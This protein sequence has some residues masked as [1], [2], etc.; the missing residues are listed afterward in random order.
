MPG[1]LSE[2]APAAPAA[3]AESDVRT[4]LARLAASNA[5]RT[6]VLQL[7]AMAV[8]AGM[9]WAEDAR[10]AALL[11]FGMALLVGLWRV[12]LGRVACAPDDPSAFEPQRVT[13]SLTANAVM[14]GLTWMLASVTILPRLGPMEEAVY[15]LL[16]CGT[17]VVGA[18]FLPFA[19]S[20]YTILVALQVLGL[21]VALVDAGNAWSLAVLA[22]CAPFGRSL[23]LAARTY[24]DT[25][26]C[27]I[28]SG[29]QARLALAA[30]EHSRDAE[31]RASEAKS[32][33]LATLS[34]EIRTPMSGVLGA[35]DLLRHAGLTPAQVALAE[36]AASSGESLLRIVNDV[37]DHAQLESGRLNLVPRPADLAALAQGV[38]RLF[39]PNAR[40]KGLCLDLSADVGDAG[41]VLVDRERL[42]QVLMNLVGNA[43]KFTR[44]GAVGVELQAR[45]RADGAAHVTL[46]V[47][48][49]GVGIGADA[50]R[51]LFEPFYQ[52][53]AGPKRGGS[54]LGL[55]ICERI[56]RQ[57]GGRIVVDSRPGAGSVF[58]VELVL[59]VA[60]AAVA[61]EAPDSALH[62]ELG[63]TFHGHVL[64]VDDNDVNRLIGTEMLQSLGLTVT[65]AVDGQDALDRLD[66]GGFD[67]VLMDVQMPVLDG[68]AATRLQ[69]ERERRLGLPR[70]TIVALT[71]NAFAE[72]I[73]TALAAGMDDHVSKPFS[74]AQL[75]RVLA[76]CL[77]RA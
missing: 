28:R 40:A 60:E 42:Q 55:S 62:A 14:T 54:G 65:E 66:S 50:C 13:R 53:P 6:A 61:D 32:R 20:A 16:A 72:D 27:A 36:T 70:T 67:L 43:V 3:E 29:A 74:R 21:A 12:T 76:A 48:D 15:L 69:R 59:A 11:T 17:L 30:L 68:H 56:V 22:L 57:M 47:R 34:H 49:T 64:L 26:A 45:R 10:L 77:I 75:C 41:R 9:G 37:L 4:A 1:T 63:G 18:K 7:A 35:I 5:Q 25:V 2:A 39:Q 19:G 38:V 51:R 52:D 58:Q 24:R 33:F 46:C 71:A 8:V 73:A 31:R 23:L 44:E